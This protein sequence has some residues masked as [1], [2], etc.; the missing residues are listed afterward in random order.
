MLD[1]VLEGVVE[2][3]VIVELMGELGSVMKMVG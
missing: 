2:M 1:V 3:I